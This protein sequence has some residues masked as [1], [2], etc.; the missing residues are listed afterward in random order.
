MYVTIYSNMDAALYT[1]RMYTLWN[2]ILMAIVAPV[3]LYKGLLMI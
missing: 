3:L 2:Y 1:Y